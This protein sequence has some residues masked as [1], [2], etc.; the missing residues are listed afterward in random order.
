MRHLGIL[1][2]EDED[3]VRA[4]H[5]RIYRNLKFGANFVVFLIASAFLLGVWL[6]PKVVDVMRTGGGFFWPVWIVVAWLLV[7]LAQAWEYYQ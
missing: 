7:L 5:I 3:P 4:E 2:D 6:A 1:G